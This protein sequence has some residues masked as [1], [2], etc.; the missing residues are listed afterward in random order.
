[1]KTKLLIFLFILFSSA[2]F[3]Q[4][5]SDAIMKQRQLQKLWDFKDS[6]AGLMYDV[7]YYELKLEVD[8]SVYGI[9]GTITTLFEMKQP[10]NVVTFDLLNNMIVDSVKYNNQLLS[11]THQ[12]HIVSIT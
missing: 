11:F 2:V 7:K 10:S 12:N 8:P 6:K 1:M 5:Y 9:S 3:A 4:E